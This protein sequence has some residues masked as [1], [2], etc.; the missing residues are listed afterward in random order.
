MVS[1]QALEESDDVDH[2]HRIINMRKDA[3]KTSIMSL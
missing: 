3:R 2:L 1:F